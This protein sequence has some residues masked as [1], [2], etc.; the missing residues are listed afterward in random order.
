MQHE[1]DAVMTQAPTFTLAR[2]AF[3]RLV[4]TS[5]DGDTHEEVIPVRA[6]PIAAPDEGLSIVSSEGHELA[7]IDRLS[8]LPAQTRALL[9]EELAIREFAPVIRAIQAVSTFSTPSTWTVDTDRGPTA[10]VLKSEDDIR[11]LAHG[12][13][14]ITGG[15]GVNFIVQDRMALDKHSRKLLERFLF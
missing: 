6:F 9:E 11:R 15:H 8:T 1:L 3:G 2:N 13:L 5:A 10:F 4:F 14:L 7:W 12:K